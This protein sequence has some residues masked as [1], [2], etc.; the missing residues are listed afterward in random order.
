[1]NNKRWGRIAAVVTIPTCIRSTATL[2][3]D[4]WNLRDAGYL[5]FIALMLVAYLKWF[6]PEKMDDDGK[7]MVRFSI[8]GEQII[9]I[10]VSIAVLGIVIGLWVVNS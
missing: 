7:K 2:I 3:L 6:T 8:S 4:G 1:V 9:L 10:L 5:A